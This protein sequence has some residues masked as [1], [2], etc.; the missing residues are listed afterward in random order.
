LNNKMKLIFLDTETTGTDIKTDRLCQLCYK[1]GD[2]IRAEYFKPPIPIP[3]DAMSVH[4]IT[5]K[6]VADKPVFQGSAMHKDL[7]TKLE[8]HIAVIHN[9]SFDSGILK[10]E[11]VE[12]P[13]KICTLRVV[14]YLDEDDV[15]PKHSLQFLRYYLGLE[16]DAPAH[17]AKGDVIILHA[18]F[19]HLL[20]KMMEK[21]PDEEA[22]IEEMVRISNS[23][24]LMKRFK[25]GKYKDQKI[26]EVVASDRG[27]VEWMLKEQ[28]KKGEGESDLALS[29]KEHLK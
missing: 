25:F 15:I 22:A 13:R 12:I 27:Y 23:P 1:V 16:I 14:K 21:I 18:I 2:E 11:G 4:H 17:D 24:A 19:A 26:S 10:N 9:A 8:D 6:M 7:K 20:A 28:I 3:V 29:L 5:N